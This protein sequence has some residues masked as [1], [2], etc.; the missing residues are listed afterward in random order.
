[1][2]YLENVLKPGDEDLPLAS[3]LL[4]QLIDEKYRTLLDE[5]GDLMC[6]VDRAG[7]FIYVNR[8]LADSLGYTKKELLRLRMRQIID[9]E[10]LQEFGERTREF[11]RTKRIHLPHFVLKTKL[12]GRVFGELSSVAFYDNQG[13]Y[14]GA[15]AVFKDMTRLIAI[16]RLEK[17]YESMMEDGIDALDHIIVILDKE[18]RIRW[19]SSSVGKYFGL[20]KARIAG[21]DMRLVLK[22]ARKKIVEG[23]ENLFLEEALSAYQARRPA[24]RVEFRLKRQ[25]GQGPFFMEYH[26]YPIAHGE[27]S[28]GR[29]EI[30]RDI[31]ERKRSEET[32]E[33]YYQQIHG[34]MEHA[35]EGVLELRTDNTVR[36]INKS[37]LDKLGYAET[38]ILDRSLYDFILP[39]EHRRLVAV[40]L[41]RQAREVTL[42]KKD[43]SFL[44]GLMSCIPLVFGPAMTHALCF[45]T[46]ISEP[47]MVSLKLRDANLTLR[48]L[49]ASLLENSLLDVR[50]GVYNDRY[51]HERLQEEVRRARRFFR[52]FSVVMIDLDFFKSVN[53]AYGHLFGDEVLRGFAGLLKGAV[54]ATDIVVRAGGEEFVVFCPDTDGVGALRV[55]QKIAQ[56]LQKTPLGNKELQLMVTASMGIASYPEAG[57]YEPLALLEAS[58]QAMYKSKILGRNRITI[59]NKGMAAAAEAQSGAFQAEAMPAIKERLANINLRNEEA[60]LE[61]LRPLSRQVGKRLGYGEEYAQRL[62]ENMRL[63]CEELDWPACDLRNAKRAGF[64][65]NLGFL[66]LPSEILAKALLNREENSLIRHHPLA[67]VS[68]IDDIPFLYPLKEVIL[69]HHERYDGRGYPKGLKGEEIPPVSRMIAVAEAYEAM[70][71]PRP[72]RPKPYSRT[73]AADLL[74]KEAGLQFDPGIVDCF[75]RRALPSSSD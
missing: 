21:E 73:E 46:D 3:R 9:P 38:E 47:K 67:S 33:Y 27:F 44:Y 11:L 64:L 8:Q 29:V 39:D 24:R 32:L 35:V 49:N 17:K 54:R 10:S 62:M 61:S 34:I 69:S 16:Q 1:M 63:L 20:D 23:D 2:D 12:G 71:S 66:G 72:Y 65:C 15:K 40:K 36:F 22:E 59:F 18:Y 56:A 52:P 25:G 6:I 5:S 7:K 74:R 4:Y 42:L 37:L 68:L 26:G 19:A 30:F 45:I 60:V 75:L 50:T 28:G 51:L 53:D 31:T 43:G 70:I 58:D 57:I 14:S 13:R 55:A 41:I 48:A